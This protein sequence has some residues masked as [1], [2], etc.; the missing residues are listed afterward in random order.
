MSAH[1]AKIAVAKQGG[2]G[3]AESGDGKIPQELLK[4]YIMYAR[5]KCHPELEGIDQEKIVNLYMKL[6]EKSS[7]IGK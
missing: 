3:D 7:S 1:P 6:C 2:R 5:T 4:K